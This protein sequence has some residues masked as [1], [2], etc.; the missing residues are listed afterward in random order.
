MIIHSFSHAKKTCPPS[1]HVYPP[2]SL[3]PSNPNPY[4]SIGIPSRN[5]KS[6]FLLLSTFYHFP[7]PLAPFPP[8]LVQRPLSPCAD[9]SNPE[10]SS[11]SP[12]LPLPLSFPLPPNLCFILRLPFHPFPCPP[13]SRL[14]SRTSSVSCKVTVFLPNAPYH[15]TSHHTTDKLCFSLLPH[16]DLPQNPNSD[17]TLTFPPPRSP[18][19]TRFYGNRT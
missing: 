5:A 3:L 10:S 6:M 13:L 8:G 2:S 18:K 1:G 12:H 14:L 7:S 15:I 16:S 19:L 4:H 17:T 9:H 11:L